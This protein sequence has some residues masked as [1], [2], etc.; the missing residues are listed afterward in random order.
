MRVLNRA[1]LRE[2][3]RLGTDSGHIRNFFNVRFWWKQLPPFVKNLCFGWWW[4]QL[5][6][7]TGKQ[8]SPL[9]TFGYRSFFSQ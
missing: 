3:W 6:G 7:N 1:I 4:M 8:F 9:F 5:P 2:V